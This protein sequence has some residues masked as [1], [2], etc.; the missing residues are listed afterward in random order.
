MDGLRENVSVLPYVLCI[1]AGTATVTVSNA[2]GLRSCMS[3]AGTPS[4]VATWA[5]RSATVIDGALA[6]VSVV[7][8]V[9]CSAAG[10][11]TV[12]VSNAPGLSNCM[13]E[14]GTPSAVAT[15]AFRSATVVD[16]VFVMVSVLPYV[17]RSAAGTAT[18]TVSA[19]ELGVPVRATLVPLVTPRSLSVWVSLVGSVPPKDTPCV[20]AGMPVTLSKRVFS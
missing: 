3:E 1:A 13:S 17:L 2:P 5:F 9:L 19:A 7:P 12:T 20:P 16:G 8:Y 15:W 10:T 4:A 11:A 18:V 6:T 14:A